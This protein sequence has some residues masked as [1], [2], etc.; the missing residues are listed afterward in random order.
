MKKTKQSP[1]KNIEELRLQYLVNIGASQEYCDPYI[2]ISKK[3]FMNGFL[4]LFC[5]LIGFSIIIVFMTLPIMN[6]LMLF[7]ILGCI[8]NIL[9]RYKLFYSILIISYVLFCNFIF[10]NHLK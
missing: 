1:P 2:P 3:T 10:F 7:S 8:Y 6:W 4:N 9:D 5:M